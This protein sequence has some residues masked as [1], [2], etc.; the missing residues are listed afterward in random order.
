MEN[1]LTNGFQ[2][3][4]VCYNGK[5]ITR[6]ELILYLFEITNL[7]KEVQ[8]LLQKGERGRKEIK[9][10]EAL[11]VRQP[12]YMPVVEK[13]KGL[14]LLSRRRKREY[15]AWLASAPQQ[16]EERRRLEEKES[17]RIAE[18]KERKNKLIDDG[19]QEMERA[20]KLAKKYE[21][22][23]CLQIIAPQYR[24]ERIPEI[25]LT[26]LFEGRAMTLSEA[27]NLYHEEEH[28]MQMLSIAKQQL[29][30]ARQAQAMQ[31]ELAWQQLEVLNETKKLQQQALDAA[32]E[33]KS[34]AKNAEFYSFLNLIM[35]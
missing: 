16:E 31:L 3:L 28:R 8:T 18:V 2:M 4:S 20:K 9:A 29:V 19:W 6:A 10:L 13:P 33:A 7:K 32:N 25:L 15:Q 12:V 21:E 23:C 24:K 30:E 17:A 1:G 14:S 26:Y 22:L 5:Q 27:L 11:E 34:A 35:S